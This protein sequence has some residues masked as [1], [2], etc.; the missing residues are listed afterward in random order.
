MNFHE[1]KIIT[2]VPVPKTC[3]TLT[4]SF[5]CLYFRIPQP[6]QDSLQDRGTGTNNSDSKF[7]PFLITTDFSLH[8]MYIC[9]THNKQAEGQFY[10]RRNIATKR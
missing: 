1:D 5:F 6:M 10:V 8:T 2:E 7:K 3:Q 9:L 4:I